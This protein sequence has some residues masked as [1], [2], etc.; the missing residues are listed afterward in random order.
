M[1][2]VTPNRAARRAQARRSRKLAALG[3]GAVLATGMATG[4]LAAFP[5]AA[6]AAT[7]TVAN[8]NDSGAGSLRQALADANPGDTIDLAGL[9]GTITLTSGQLDIEDPVT[10]TGPG[11][12]ALTIS[13]NGASHVFSMYTDLSG[14]TVTISGLTITGGNAEQ[15]GGVFFNCDTGSGSLV[16]SDA[17]VS[18]NTVTN[19]GGG[20]YFDRCDEGGDLSVVN[21]VV[22]NNTAS[23]DST[24]GA[25]GIWF[26][27][28]DTLTIQN[29][30]VSGNSAAHWGGGGVTAFATDGVNVQNSTIS[31][32]TANGNGG[33]LY[34]W[35]SAGSM[36]IANS[37]ISGNSTNGSGGGIDVLRGSLQLVQSTISGNTAVDAGDGLYIGYVS[38]ELG[39]G[40]SS[41]RQA[42][43]PRTEAA[44]EHR[45][46]AFVDVLGTIV[47]ANA[48]GTD[49][50]N[51]DPQSDSTLTLA[52]S[53]I[54]VV[55]GLTPT[56]GGGNQMGVSDPGLD[57]LANNGGA[58]QTMALKTGSVAIDKGPNP[59][60]AFPGNEFDQRGSGFARVVNDQVDVGAFEVQP[61]ALAPEVLVIQ[62]RFTG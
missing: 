44:T 60:P 58:T 30:T 45:G 21:S 20:L 46:Q 56:D 17:V 15:G 52:S 6:G 61:P 1:S 24:G 13:G 37:T 23:A 48:D 53:V 27:E 54:G 34:L 42:N 7:I 47:A 25:G 33:G 14:G 3:S 8:T 40:A 12:S 26:D 4:A 2:D 10:I 57:P 36:Q 43:S 16:V 51:G 35:T 11:A 18:G 62:P 41:D 49:D 31:G 9:T 29:T 22:A 38:G 5:S 39:A 59:E 55:N 19:L 32:N 28:G 50:I